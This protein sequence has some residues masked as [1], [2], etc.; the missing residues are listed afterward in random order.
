MH[1]WELAR[2]EIDL[3][4][5]SALVAVGGDGTLHEVINGMLQRADGKKIAISFI[6]NGSGNDLVGCLG[7]KDI[8][9]ALDWLVKGDIIQMDVNKVLIDYESEDEI[10]EH[11]ARQAKFRYS[12][13]NASVGYIAKCVHK[14]DSYKPYVGRLCYTS[15]AVVNFFG[16][17]NETFGIDFE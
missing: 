11:I 6:P 15:S 10:P 14:A 16:N 4:Q 2:D 3:T 9:Q 1:A 12:V 17:D 8:N 5:F 13:I 7:I